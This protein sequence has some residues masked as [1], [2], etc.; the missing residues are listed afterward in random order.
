MKINFNIKKD[1][2]GKIT[3]NPIPITCAII[4]YFLTAKFLFIVFQ[5]FPQLYHIKPEDISPFIGV[6]LGFVNTWKLNEVIA[7]LSLTLYFVNVF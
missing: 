3:F 5:S 1:D 4:G 2:D 7:I 6:F